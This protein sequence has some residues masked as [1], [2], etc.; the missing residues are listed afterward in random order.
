MLSSEALD[1]YV[2]VDKFFAGKIY[3]FSHLYHHSTLIDF[4]VIIRHQ[5]FFAIIFEWQMIHSRP[6]LYSECRYMNNNLSLESQHCF[7]FMFILIHVKEKI[8]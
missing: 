3:V 2:S 5:D 6:A 8:N 4:P 7:E 1:K